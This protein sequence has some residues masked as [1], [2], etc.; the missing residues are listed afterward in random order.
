MANQVYT[1]A[2]YIKDFWKAQVG[3]LYHHNDLISFYLVG[4]GI[5]FLGRCL[6]QGSLWDKG[7]GRS[8]IRFELAIN[9]LE[10]FK[11]YRPYLFGNTYLTVKDRIQ[12][13]SKEVELLKLHSPN[14]TGIDDVCSK[15]AA[16]VSTT[17]SSGDDYDLYSVLRCG[18]VH[19][20]LPKKDM[21]LASGHEADHLQKK[22]DGLYLDISCLSEDF[23]NACDEVLRSTTDP[24]VSEN[25]HRK[26]MKVNYKNRLNVSAG[27][28][29]P[30]QAATGSCYNGYHNSFDNGNI[31][32]SCTGT[33]FK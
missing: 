29:T 26:C 6:D 13:I 7:E 10:S 18:L 9:R 28:V 5:E 25:L 30:Q 20:G 4:V 22:T 24:A 16:C 2:D 32:Q 33:N 15:L 8:R 21:V 27:G 1:V 17:K 14:L 23:V 12:A 11:S 31:I 19:E 3:V